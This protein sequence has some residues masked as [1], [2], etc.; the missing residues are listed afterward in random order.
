M[1]PSRRRRTRRWRRSSRT[2]RCATSRRS[3]GNSPV[4]TANALSRSA[5]AV[6]LC[7]QHAT[8]ALFRVVRQVCKETSWE[9][10]L[11]AYS[12]PRLTNSQ[13]DNEIK[14]H[15]PGRNTSRKR[16][17]LR[18]SFVTRLTRFRFISRMNCW[19][20]REKPNC[21]SLCVFFVA[22]HEHSEGSLLPGPGAARA[23]PVR[24]G[25]CESHAR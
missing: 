20:G 25:H 6:F 7:S 12:R 3:S 1:F 23:E 18:G 13:L 21:C 10:S 4:R 16:Y 5:F 22:G 11:H 8:R 17:T 19:C 2:G 24:R 15:C 9:I 14:S